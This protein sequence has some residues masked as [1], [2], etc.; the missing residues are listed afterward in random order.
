MTLYTIKN[1]HW[2]LGGRITVG[3]F[4]EMSWHLI[5]N[6]IHMQVF[7]F[8]TKQVSAESNKTWGF[9][10]HN[11]S[12]FEICVD[13]EMQPIVLEKIG[14]NTRKYHTYTSPL[15]TGSYQIFQERLNKD[16]MELQLT[17]NKWQLLIQTLTEKILTVVLRE[18]KFEYQEESDQHS[19]FGW[20]RPSVF[21]C[22]GINRSFGNEKIFHV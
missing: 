19:L 7:E 14:S 2:D 17:C 10:F 18:T 15:A 3:S 9:T 20:F 21:R 1:V 5:K 16:D 13:E 6:H 22:K 12:N 4:S 11:H 8:S